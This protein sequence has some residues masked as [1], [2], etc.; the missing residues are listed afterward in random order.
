M[1]DTGAF[2]I[3]RRVSLGVLVAIVCNLIAGVWYAA[4]IDSRVESL[5][6]YMIIYT[7]DVTRLRRAIDRDKDRLARLEGRMDMLI[8]EVSK[9]NGRP[10][11]DTAK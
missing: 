8:T 4:K 7:S 10:I 1:P 6:K 3:D 9:I 5:E 11:G 2:F